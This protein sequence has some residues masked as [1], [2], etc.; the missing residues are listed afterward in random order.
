MA[1]HIHDTVLQVHHSSFHCNSV[2]LTSFEAILS[3]LVLT[4]L[5]VVDLIRAGVLRRV[6]NKALFAE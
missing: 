6:M 4:L 2:D 1:D 5:A 3:S